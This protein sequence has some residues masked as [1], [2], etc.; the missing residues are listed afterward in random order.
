MVPPET[1]GPAHHNLRIQTLTSTAA[2][3]GAA[4]STASHEPS[5]MQ[6]FAYQN[7]D[8]VASTPLNIIVGWLDSAGAIP[9]GWKFCNGDVGTPDLRDYQIKV[10]VNTSTVGLYSGPTVTMHSHSHSIASH[11]HDDPGTHTNHSIAEADT[12]LIIP[13]NGPYFSLDGGTAHS[14]TWS[15][16]ASS[17]GTTTLR[18]VTG[19]Q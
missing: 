14:H 1:R 17:I 12:N 9:P 10:T 18:I 11:T 4:L 6:L 7:T 15:L 16:G 19:K 8:T 13:A 3:V 5:A 2:S